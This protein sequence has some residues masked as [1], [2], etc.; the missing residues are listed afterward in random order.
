MPIFIVFWSPVENEF[1]SDSGQQ[2]IDQ[3]GDL[4][5]RDHLRIDKVPMKVKDEINDLCSGHSLLNI[6]REGH[7]VDTDLLGCALNV[8]L[9]A[10]FCGFVL[11]AEVRWDYNGTR[12]KTSECFN[13]SLAFHV[14]RIR[15]RHVVQGV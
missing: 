5:P 10:Q 12:W 11:H 2:A 4:P 7:F 13:A 3:T 8:V 14:D 15:A 9:E 6:A 1:W